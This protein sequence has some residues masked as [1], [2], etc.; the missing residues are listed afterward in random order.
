MNVPYLTLLLLVPIAG[1]L[2]MGLLTRRE[3]A[4]ALKGFALAVALV[5]F[6]L[7][8]AVWAGFDPEASP[9]GYIGAVRIGR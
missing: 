6:A 3:S 8:I 2:L 4:G 7:S 9:P 5:N 1:A